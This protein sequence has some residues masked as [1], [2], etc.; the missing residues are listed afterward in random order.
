MQLPVKITPDRIRDSI[1]QIFFKSSVPSEALV[2]IFYQSLVNSGWKYANRPNEIVPSKGLVL[3]FATN[4]Q[5]FF[6]K[7]EV[8]FQLH[9]NHS[10]AFNCN[11]NY[12]GWERYS[13]YIKEVLN[14]IFES[15][16]VLSFVRIG[17]RYISEFPDIDI[18]EKLKFKISFPQ[19]ENIS[20]SSYRL[21][22]DEGSIFKTVNIASK[23]PATTSFINQDKRI[24]FISMLDIDI[25]KK[26][27]S[28]S[29]PAEV[30]NEIDDL[31]LAEKE[32]FFSLLDPDFLLSLN[33]E[34][35]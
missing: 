33:P 14:D 21:A 23:L 8:R 19:Y 34:Y 5:H 16:T 10:I 28:A 30:W 13:I 25:V 3:E 18:L 11:N 6:L 7:D 24:D 1:V 17:I 12:I 26:T 31:H 9:N 32:L 22:F 20:N 4:T 15:G 35:V 2:G 27:L 29:G